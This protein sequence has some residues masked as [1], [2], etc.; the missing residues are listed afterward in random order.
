MSTAEFRLLHPVLTERVRLGIMALLAAE[1]EPVSFKE[2][3]HRLGLT[4]GNLSSH[5]RKL[6]EAGFIEVTKD[7]VD[8]K[9]L[10]TLR[11]SDEGR[12]AVKLYLETIER[13]LRLDIEKKD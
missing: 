10:T 13:M 9:P 8:R 1:K 4:K 2:L 6:E 5:L 7:F 11:C 12:R 3:E